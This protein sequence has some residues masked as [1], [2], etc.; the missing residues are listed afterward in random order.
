M[1]K[2]LVIA[3]GLGLVLGLTGCSAIGQ[4]LRAAL[5]ELAATPTAEVVTA[6]P[7]PLR[8]ELPGLTAADIVRAEEDLVAGIYKQVSPAVVHITSRVMEMSFFFGPLPREG[9]GSGFVIDGEGH[10]VTNYHVIENAES[11]EVTLVDG[12]VLPA[13]VIGTDP[14]SD[15][16][17]IQVDG[18][19]GKLQPI[20]LGHSADL[21]VGQRAIAI[22]NP[23]GLDRTLTT[24]VI[25]SLGRPLEIDDRVLYDVIQ[26][27]A[28]INPGNSG[29][30]L[31]DSSGQVIGV[32]TAIQSEAENIGF[33]VPVDTVRR[34]VPE[35]LA[36]GRYRHP[37]TGFEG[38]SITPGL[39]KALELP[40]ERGILV[41]RMVRGSPAAEAGLR[42]ATRQV[43]VG[44]SRVLAGG[45]VIT[46]ID[47]RPVADNNDLGRYLE[48]QA[49][50]GQTVELTVLR[51]GREQTLSL[52]LAESP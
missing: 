27:D 51:E 39:A 31:L 24:G 1:R 52:Q 21:Q 11:V 32:N 6:T 18:L 48:L 40:V 10:I 45:D 5:P 30:P 26:T 8:V 36:H 16:A 28:A 34:V 9:T 42:G 33:A 22:G 43:I 44:N 37:W 19:A 35:L 17:L 20:G 2:V 41:A 50:V 7:S 25:S 49:R 46:A 38:Y 12:S 14:Q 3:L 47:G 23:F 4:A 13:R 29:G 15:L